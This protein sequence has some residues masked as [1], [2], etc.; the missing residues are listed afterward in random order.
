MERL[1]ET[2][3][4]LGQGVSSATFTGSVQEE[5]PASSQHRRSGLGVR[6]P[7]RLSDALQT[8][9]KGLPAG[10]EGARAPGCGT[11]SGSLRG[12]CGWAVLPFCMPASQGHGLQK[13]TRAFARARLSPRPPHSPQ[14]GGAPSRAPFHRCGSRGAE[15]LGSLPRVTQLRGGGAGTRPLAFPPLCCP[16]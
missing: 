14:L 4:R 2:K 10:Q 7:R 11:G 16:D 15:G 8:E 13:K 9:Q 6:A 1:S 3:G 12:A 5:A